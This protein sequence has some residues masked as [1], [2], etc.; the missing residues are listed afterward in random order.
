MVI[1]VSYKAVL[2]PT[3]ACMWDPSLYTSLSPL[4]VQLPFPDPPQEKQAAWSSTGESRRLGFG[5]RLGAQR[6]AAVVVVSSPTAQR[7]SQQAFRY[8]PCSGHSWRQGQPSV[9]PYYLGRQARPGAPCPQ[10]QLQ[11]YSSGIVGPWT[12]QEP[13]R[14]HHISSCHPF[15]VLQYRLTSVFF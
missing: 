10:P 15:T 9:F 1:M 8:R 7:S 6:W 5:A 11:G 14:G 3:G 2:L 4:E 13:T 12:T